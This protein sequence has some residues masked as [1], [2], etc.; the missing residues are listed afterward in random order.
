[1]ADPSKAAIAASCASPTPYANIVTAGSNIL[2][3]LF[4]DRR[5]T[6]IDFP[7]AVARAVYE[8]A[9]ARRGLPTGL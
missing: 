1:M 9:L 8:R 3:W 2:W 4:G 7:R 6:D 5:G